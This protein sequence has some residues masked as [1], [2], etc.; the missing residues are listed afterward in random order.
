[1]A[2]SIASA[3]DILSINRDGSQDGVIGAVRS[4]GEELLRG[5]PDA[6]GARMRDSETP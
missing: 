2:H 5:L 3:L 4:L 6:I 1:L